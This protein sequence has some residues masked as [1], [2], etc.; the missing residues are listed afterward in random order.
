MLAGA[1]IPS[2]STGRLG[3]LFYGPPG[4]HPRQ[5]LLVLRA[6]AKVARRVEAL[7]CVLCRL[8]W[9]GALVKR[10]LDRFRAH[11]SRTDIGQS[12]A[13]VAVHLLRCR[14]HDGPVEEPATELDVLVGAV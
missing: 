9:F 11:R 14:A 12:D 3:R 2:N 1:V 6:G 5:V 13:P 8:L 7:G 10:F 4:Q